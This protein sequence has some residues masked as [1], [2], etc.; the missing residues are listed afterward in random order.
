MDDWY[1]LLIQIPTD[2]IIPI[3]CVCEQH[4]TFNGKWWVEK[5]MHSNQ[6]KL[7][8][9]EKSLRIFLSPTYSW[10]GAEAWMIKINHVEI[11]SI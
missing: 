3:G 6:Q 10:N 5:I 8:L 7:P 1:N 9:G 2:A 4:Y 11:R